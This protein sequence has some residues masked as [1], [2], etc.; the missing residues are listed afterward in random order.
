MMTDFSSSR[1]KVKSPE[2]NLFFNLSREVGLNP[3]QA[4]IAIDIFADHLQN[5]HSTTRPPGVV[6]HTAVKATEPAGKPIKHC[7][8]IPVKLTIYHEADSSILA[9]DGTV[10]MRKVLLC[11]LAR[12]AYE[13]GG[14][15]SYGDLSR[16]LVVDD[17]TIKDLAKQ[18]RAEGI[19]LPTRGWIKDI[20][21]EPSHKQLIADL[22]GRGYSTTKIRAMTRHGEQ[23]IGRYQHQFSL[24]I[25]LLETYPDAS[26]D[27]YCQ[28]SELSL[29]AFSIY[30]EVYEELK[31]RQDC[32]PHL[33]RLKRRFELDPQGYSIT[34]TTF[35]KGQNDPA[36]RL[37]EQNLSNALRQTIEVD[38][39]TTKRVAKAVT[40]DLMGLIDSSFMLSESAR[41]GEVV[42]FADARL[43]GIISGEKLTDRQVVPVQLPI[44][45]EEAKEILRKDETISRRRARL[46]VFLAGAALEQGAVMSIGGL[47]ELVHTTPSS[48]AKNLR[49]L[50][51]DYHVQV[52]TKG[53]VED[54]GP[55]LTHKDWIIDLDQHG[56]TAE[57]ISFLSRHAPSSRDRYI[58]TYRRVE[59][60]MQLE[61]KI[62]EVDK[63]TKVLRLQP[64]V[65]R[66]YLD[67]IN[68]YHGNHANTEL[69]SAG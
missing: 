28:L 36:K 13:Q 60:L 15:L 10:A 19:W 53:I 58:E 67:L 23:A 22:L 18:L 1:D 42:V 45:T 30:R 56:F 44:Y 8:V 3:A 65:A 52:E 39:G 46:A 37:K 4:R 63:I 27:Q 57:E 33:E 48:L 16:L 6:I 32:R 54:S 35:G 47:A 34:K 55:T 14:L 12:E 21:P 11:R 43:D 41:P 2:H 40:E 7:Q 38:L 29:K 50:A 51:V 24:V 25:F 68:H 62:P 20:G 64:H 66:Q 26:D 5:Y 17:S 61:G 69:L 59:T 31:Q 49:D 9:N